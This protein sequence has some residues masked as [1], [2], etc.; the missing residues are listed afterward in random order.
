MKRYQKISIAAVMISGLVF[1]VSVTATGNAKYYV[2]GS[3]FGLGVARTM[4]G[5]PHHE[6]EHGFTGDLSPGQVRALEVFSSM[7]GISIEPVPL[8]YISAPPGACSPWP[9]C[10]NG[11]GGSNGER[12]YYPS[13]QTPWGI[14]RIYNNPDAT[15]TF[16]GQGVDVAVLDTGV[17]KD[18]PDLTQRVE[19]CKDFT[20]RGIKSGCRDGY[21]H[22]THVAGTILA[23]AGADGLGIYGIAPQAH[24][25]AYKVCGNNG[26]CWADDIAVAISHAADQGAEI[27][28]MSLG[29]D[30]QSS[31]IRDA[32]D[33]A[34]TKGVL[35]VAA[36]GNDGPE[37]N[38][39]DY[40]GANVKVVAVGATDVDD[41]V[42][43]WSSRGVND[44]DY[45]VEEREV[46]FGAPGVNI[47]STWNDGSYYLLSGTSM[48]TPHI[49]GLAA[50][51]WQ[52]TAADTR[53]YLQSLAQDIWVAG[54]DPA[55]GFGLPHLP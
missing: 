25:Y 46:E 35:V 1:S 36:A 42:P 11:G 5:E 8:Y 47:E 9:E 20:K 7:L 52:G 41:N 10:K 51:L 3:D 53:A 49:S 21:G 37:V 4:V 43:D 48:A 39:I 22:G 17:Y 32:I 12:A 14:E 18:H 31:L 45:V 50:K 26:G 27:V 40:P 38:S 15:S 30:V 29:A 54:D 24:L 28:S 6:F 34:I 55:T 23:D 13:D 44:G 19:Q 16:G 33:Y 2:S